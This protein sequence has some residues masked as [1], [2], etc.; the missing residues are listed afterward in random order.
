MSV[1][2]KRR[3]LPWAVIRSA[4]STAGSVSHLEKHTEHHET[5]ETFKARKHMIIPKREVNLF[6]KTNKVQ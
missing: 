1:Y 2:R 5:F 3:T 6:S 4:G